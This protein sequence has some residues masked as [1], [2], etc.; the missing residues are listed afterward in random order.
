MIPVQEQQEPP[1]FD[2][3]VRQPGLEWLKDNGIPPD[4]PPPKPGKLPTYWR[5]TLE[6]LWNAYG[7]VCAYHC[8]YFEWSCRPNTDHYV[9]KSRN[10]GLAYEWSNYRLSCFG[11]NSDKRNFDDI[12]DPFKIAPETFLLELDTGRMY[13]NPNLPE[14]IHVLAQ[15]TIDRLDLND[16]RLQEMRA[17]HFETYL[18]KDVSAD[19]LLRDSPFVHYEA[20]RQGLLAEQD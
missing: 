11:A 10:A 18:L 2:A 9:A 17:R 4:L 8:Y 1:H 12:L 5:R 13:P 14:E 6:D 7:R 15:K 3:E 20:A 16:A 19:H